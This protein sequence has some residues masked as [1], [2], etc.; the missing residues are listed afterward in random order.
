[1]LSISVD[2]ILKVL[3]RKKYKIFDKNLAYNVNI[4]GIRSLTSVPNNFDDTL[5]LF[6]RGYD[7][8]WIL[9]SYPI[10]T[11]PGLPYLLK[12]LNPKGAAILCEGQYLNTYK[13]DIHNGKYLALCQRLGDV[14]VFRDSNKN[15]I[16]EWDQSNTETGMFGINIHKG[17]AW[18]ITK[19][20]SKH[21]AGCQVFQN[22]EHFNEF[23]HI[24]QKSA[25][26]YGNKFTYTLINEKDFI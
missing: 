11:D 18:G 19:Y 14:K 16:L 6:F 2:H 10:T 9:K 12:P 21:S 7:K 20:V 3:K 22:I 24:C 1:M 25:Q 26:L 15:N 23:I 13:L 5:I 17:D 8:E 4:V